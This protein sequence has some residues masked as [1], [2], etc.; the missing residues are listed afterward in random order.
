MLIGVLGAGERERPLLLRLSEH[1]K[2]ITISQNSRIAYLLPVEYFSLNPKTHSGLWVS[3]DLN[4]GTA[5]VSLFMLSFYSSK[6]VQST[7]I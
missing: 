2:H 6:H 5:Y 1:S 7:S 3:L 4:A